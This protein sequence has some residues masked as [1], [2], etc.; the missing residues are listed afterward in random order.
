MALKVILHPAAG[1]FPF[2][3]PAVSQR[4]EEFNW[5]RFIK[6]NAFKV[7]MLILGS[8]RRLC[9]SKSVRSVSLL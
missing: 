3:F 8:L 4:A 6:S 1:I 7:E 9:L 5:S 2:E